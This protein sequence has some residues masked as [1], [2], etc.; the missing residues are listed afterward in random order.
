MIRQSRIFITSC[1]DPYRNLAAEELLMKEVQDDEILLF[2]WQN[3]KAVVIGR[4][5]NAWQEC[6]VDVLRSDGIRIARRLSGGGAVYHDT[7]NQNFTFI[8]KEENYDLNRQ[9]SVILRAVQS[10]GIDAGFTGRNDICASG[11][12]FSGNA[13]YDSRHAK[14]H[15]GT[16]MIDVDFTA[17]RKYLTPSAQKLAAKGVSSVES[18]VINLSELSDRVTPQTFRAAMIDSVQ[19]VYHVHPQVFLD[20]FSVLNPQELDEKTKQLSSDEWIYGRLQAFNQEI[21]F[22]TGRQMIT[23][24]LSTE[25]GIITG[26]QVF[27]DEM[28]PQTAG[29][30]AEKLRGIAYHKDNVEQAVRDAESL[31]AKTDS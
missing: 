3:E 4:N 7:G 11:R 5:Q 16:I 25:Q 31:Q 2:L 20:D 12:K 14:Y 19:S 21:S 28:N 6:P 9:L 13:F 8:A 17:I 10:F 22:H 30:I 23:I 15:H 27:S 1:T 18:R 26:A 29:L 24:R